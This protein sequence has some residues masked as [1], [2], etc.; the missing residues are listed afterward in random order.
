MV[1][2]VVDI[3]T[4]PF[5]H[6]WARSRFTTSLG[7]TSAEIGTDRFIHEIGFAS[8]IVV[9]GSNDRSHSTSDIIDIMGMGDVDLCAKLLSLALRC[10]LVFSYATDAR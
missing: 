1:G 10:I 9:Q 8:P 7:S 3:R 5:G 6:L 2:V 4:S